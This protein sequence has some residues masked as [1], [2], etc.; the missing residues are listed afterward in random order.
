V[1]YPDA[2]AAWGDIVAGLIAG[3]APAPY[4]PAAW[5]APAAERFELP[6]GPYAV[7]HV[8]A[9]TPL[10]QWDPA[11]WAAL[12]ANLAAKDIAPVWSAGRGEEPIVARCD[13]DRRYRSYAGELGLPQMWR[14]LADSSLLVCPD[15]GIAHLGR[16]VGTPTVTLFGPGSATIAGAGEFWRNAPYRAVTVD[17]FPCRDQH[18]LFKREIAWAQRCERLPPACTHPRCMDAIGIDAVNAAIADLGVMSEVGNAQ[19]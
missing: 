12:A 8:G 13:P 11:R 7:L 6:T 2:P 15:T 17:P 14:L 3:P 18:T 1:P 9:S 16:I 19:G 4:R 10:K 5:P